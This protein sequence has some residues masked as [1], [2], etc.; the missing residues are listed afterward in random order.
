MPA[1]PFLQW[2]AR[3]VL[4]LFYRE[5]ELVGLHNLPPTGPVIVVAN[6]TN[7]LVD[8]AMVTGFLPRI[9]R[10]VAASTV[11]RYTP[12][13]P[14]I[15][16]AGVIPIYRK[17]EV[18]GAAQRNR[19]T[20]EA[21]SRH[22]IDNG[23]IA[24]FPEGESHNEPRVKPLKS[25]TARMAIRAQS[26]CRATQVRIVPVGLSY[27]AKG[28]FRSRALMELGEPI[29]VPAEPP[30]AGRGAATRALTNAIQQGLIDVTQNYENRDLARL[31]G[32]A[33]EMFEAPQ[34]NV[35]S[36]PALAATSERRRD[37]IQRYAWLRKAHPA[38]TAAAWETFSAYDAELR[39]NGLR[40]AH[41]GMQASAA[42]W[43][44][45]ILRG[46]A[47]LGLRLPVALVGMALNFLPFLIVQVLALR[48]DPD[49]RATW[50]VFPSVI[51]APVFWLLQGLAAGLYLVGTAG[52]VVFL[53][54]PLSIPLTLDFV[55]RAGRWLHDFRAWRR[56]S[57]DGQLRD[58]LKAMRAAA[59]SQLDQM[60]ALVETMPEP[61]QP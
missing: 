6:H 11:W 5:V 31:I 16:M 37:F 9:P 17:A 45:H 50:Q 46:L 57:R 38:Q 28:R 21:T 14:L 42:D 26:E 15:K 39:A 4:R 2:L 59:L 20:F 53:A 18:A 43:R 19:S 3:T 22:L 54:A 52:V 36:Q 7:S 49:L 34:P 58:H 33:A 24:V 44:R 41:I 29:S 47:A 1:D 61:A 12:L 25:G 10:L 60:A 27:D 55:D 56:L 23:V 8:G 40:D 32:R 35:S 51:L 48:R 30:E 13:I